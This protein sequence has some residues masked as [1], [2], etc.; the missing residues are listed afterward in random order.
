MDRRHFLVISFAGS[1]AAAPLTVEAQ[2]VGKVYRIGMI[3][4]FPF[5]HAEIRSLAGA[6]L[7]GM[8]ELGYVP[9]RNLVLE[10]RSAQGRVEGLPKLF[11]ALVSLRVDL[12]IVFGGTPAA[13]VARQANATIPTVAPAMGDPVSDGIVRS[14]AQPGGT[15]TGSTFLGPALVPKRIE[16]MKQTVPSLG[17]L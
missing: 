2:H 8:G 4:T 7:Q 3:S 9:G 12:I 14:P 15:I 11:A 6:F 10:P 5:E 16:F 13:L 17:R 1:F